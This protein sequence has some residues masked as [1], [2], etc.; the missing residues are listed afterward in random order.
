MSG[1]RTSASSTSRISTARSGSSRRPPRGYPRRSR[2]SVG[3]PHLRRRTRSR[4][5]SGGGRLCSCSRSRSCSRRPSRPSSLVRGRVGRRPRRRFRPNHVGVID[6]QRTRSSPRSPSGSSQ[7]RLRRERAR[8][9][10]ATSSDRTLTKIDP[11][12]R[13]ATATFT[14]GNRTPTGIAV[15]LGAVWVAHGVR[16]DVSRVEPQFGQVTG[17][18]P[19]GGT[20]FGSPYGSVASGRRLGV[21]C[22]RR[23]DARPARPGRRAPGAWSGRDATGGPRRRRG[24]DLGHELGQCKRAAV[25][26]QDL[27]GRPG[28]DRQRRK[29]PD[30]DRR[31]GRRHLGRELR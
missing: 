7:G 29:T 8:S 15:G 24:H 14:L 18:T 28:W 6:P 21:G 30:G 1:C 25:Q 13:S 31:R 16:G 17:V 5:R 10:S 2:P 19:A 27:H 3:W 22:V 9:G 4:R 26:R 20:A 11:D 23:L 12:T